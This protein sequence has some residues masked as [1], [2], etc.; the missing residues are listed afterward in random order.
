MQF[1]FVQGRC[2][3]EPGSDGLDNGGRARDLWVVAALFEIHDLA[4]AAVVKG[5]G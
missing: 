5:W 2:T 1:F 4:E 3:L